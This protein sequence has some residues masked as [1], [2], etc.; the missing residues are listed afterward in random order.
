ML[1][2][3]NVGVKRDQRWILRGMG[4]HASRGEVVA[5]L[6]P[7]GSG[8]TTFLRC[9]AGDLTPDEGEVK[10]AGREIRRQTP[11]ALARHRAVL[12]QDE[13]GVFPFT[14]REMVSLGRSPHRPAGWE[15][16]NDFRIIDRAMAEAGC[17]DLKDRF[18]STLSGGETRRVQLA[19]VLAQEAPIVLLDEPTNHLD[20]SHQIQLLQTLRKLADEQACVIVTLHDLTM[21]AQVADRV[22]LLR[23]GRKFAEGTPEAVLTPHTIAAVFGVRC[24]ITHDSAGRPVFVPSLER[25]EIAS[26]EDRVP[27]PGER[28]DASEYVV[29]RA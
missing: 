7:N 13:L 2:A 25:A 23:D 14:A 1:E 11:L 27:G 28:E 24:E 6:G 21:A 9:L 16:A 3:A 29:G 15:T 5:M 19:R 22:I 4:L 12:A 8:K 10:I 17:T 20:P 18:V 26:I